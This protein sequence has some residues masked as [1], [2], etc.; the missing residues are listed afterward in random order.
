[1]KNC[2]RNI[3][4]GAV[5]ALTIVCSSKAQA[6]APPNIVAK[7]A[8]NVLDYGAKGDGVT[9]DT[10]AFIQALQSGR[11][12]S[13]LSPSP[14][15]IYVPPGRY[16]ISS[17]L[18]IWANTSLVG[19]WTNPPTL[20]LAPR[21][22]GFQDPTNPQ[23]FLVT[24]GGYNVPDNTTDWQTRTD[25]FNGSSNQTFS[26]HVRD[27]VIKI[28]SGNPGA[29]G[30]YWWCAQDTSLRNVKINAGS[31]N[32]CIYVG[33]WGGQS[34]IANC[35]FIGGRQGLLATATSQEFIR[36]CTFTGQSQNAITAYNGLTNF[37]FLDVDFQN[38]G[39]I[40]ILASDAYHPA[41]IA[42]INCHFAN[43]P[44]GTFAQEPVAAL[45]HFERM[46]FDTVSAV[47][48]FLQSVIQNGV[49][50]Q[51]SGSN[52]PGAFL[53]TEG[54]INSPIYYNNQWITGT[55]SRLNQDIYPGSWRTPVFP[56][57]NASCVN[58]KDLGAAGDG[59]TD[60]TQVIAN[61]LAS[62]NEIYFPTGTYVISAP[63]TINAGQKLFG[64][65]SSTLA[66]AAD[67]PAF[68]Y[69][70]TASVLTVQG[71]GKKGVVLF[72]I[73]ISNPAP[74]GFAVTWTADPS[75][76]MMDCVVADSS[77]SVT[78]LPVLDLEQGGGIFEGLWVAG[79]EYVPEG[80]LV[81][82]QG[83]TY[84]YQIS[85]EHYGSYSLVVQYAANL[86]LVNWE[87]EYGGNPGDT[88]VTVQIVGSQGVYVYGMNA[89]APAGN[90][91]N[92][93][94]QLSNNTQ[95]RLWNLQE[96]NLPYLLEDCTNEPC[97]ELGTL[98]SQVANVPGELL[99]GYIQD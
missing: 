67:A 18:I 26:I 23:P 2:L 52:T 84:C 55:D 17:T 35:S 90:W 30:I 19:E 21:T 58:I 25:D 94:L 68:S 65:V 5:V 97:L 9:D 53:S 20:I 63:L 13:G 69:G 43:M 49:V 73:T 82:S 78:P 81:Q 95:L 33:D 28:G 72:G 44:Q 40:S 32:G 22:R 4:L 62:Y 57:P 7:Y 74:G 24:A 88:G 6:S 41:A 50:T 47:P 71:D 79:D 14:Q 80:I 60:D 15:T 91:P 93:L 77:Y 59:V 48:P 99:S 87:S 8:R 56:R 31:G 64:E 1:M 29:W 16:V 36:S 61:A 54:Q 42:M 76:V 39:P 98:G 38:T 89:G 96:L 27:L 83:P 70:S 11:H 12:Q 75:S 85:N 37:T 3:F 51:W 34:V 92:P 10:Q 86:L 45:L 46:T 66:V